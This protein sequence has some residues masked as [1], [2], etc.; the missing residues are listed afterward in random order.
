MHF[1]APALVCATHAHG[2]TAVIARLLTADHGLVAAYVAG[3]RGRQLRPVLIPGNA[4][5]ADLRSKT[6]SQLPFA[7]V[8]LLQSRGPWLTEP[9]PAA[10]IAWVTAL[11]ASALPERHP[12]PALYEALSALIEAVCMAPSARG[13]ALALLSYEVLLLRELGYGV[14]VQR[15][16]PSD[17]AAI[18]DAF[19]RIGRELA[20]YPLAD[21][22]R[23]VMAARDLLR[24]RLKRIEG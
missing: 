21:R 24:E 11:T 22:R 18:L 4:V 19:D 23:D 3:G 12:Y 1:R 10:A 9:L 5:D 7:R 13:W 8:E 14:P 2:E 15:P 17:W 16:D 20:R 6:E